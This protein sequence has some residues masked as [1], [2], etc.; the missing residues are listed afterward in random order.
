MKKF[1]CALLLLLLLCT[2]AYALKAGDCIGV[3]APASKISKENVNIAVKLL[4]SQGYKVKLA[5]SVS[6]AY[7]HFAGTDEV[8]ARDINNFFRDS[9]VKA[10]LCARGGYGAARILDKLDYDMIA[11]HPKPLIGY[12]DITA[13]HVVLWERCRIPTIH[14]PM[15]ATFAHANLNTSYTRNNFFAGLR[16]T[17]PI[18]KLPMPEGRMLRTMTPGQAEGVIIGGNLTVLSSLVG[19]PYE[20][21][22]KGALLL[23]EE[24][25]EKTYRIDRM[26]NQLWQNGLLS[27][28]NGIMFGD[29]IDCNDDEENFTLDD[30][31]MRYAK[32]SGKPTIRGVPSGHGA[33]N[34]FI[35]FGVHAV[36]S[37]GKKGG[38]SLVIDR[39]AFV[40]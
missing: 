30:V 36:M 13:L 12:S 37:A 23:I 34:A 40:E 5:P 14:A 4:K 3:V 17:K 6:S 10:I 25:G 21:K 9:E 16:N 19:T 39:A 15:L 35:P 18:G 11:K 28:V 7:G 24:V 8:R 1:L 33:Y 31:L 22:G 26:L 20:L 27:R 32:L 29:F 2:A 38:A